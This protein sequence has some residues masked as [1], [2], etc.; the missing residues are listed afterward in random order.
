MGALAQRLAA[1]GERFEGRRKGK[2]AALRI[3]V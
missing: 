1:F 2:L 3:A